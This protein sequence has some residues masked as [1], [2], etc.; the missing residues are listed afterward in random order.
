M[1]RRR[2]AYQKRKQ[3]KFAMFLVAAV[4]L[5]LVVAVSVRKHQ[6]Q[7]KQEEID[8]YMAETRN[9]DVVLHVKPE[10]ANQIHSS[11]IDGKKC[12]VIPMD[13]NDQATINGINTTL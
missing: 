4:L 8:N 1:A 12:I 6:L 11:V 10:K 9:Y 13:E 3:N 7:E 5:M 2:V